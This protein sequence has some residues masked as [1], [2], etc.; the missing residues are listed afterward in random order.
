MPAAQTNVLVRLRHNRVV[1]TAPPPLEKR[2][3]GHPRWYGERFAFNDPAT[4]PQPDAEAT[5]HTTTKQGRRLVIHAQ[6]WYEMRLRGTRAYPMHRCP[7]TLVRIM[8]TTLEGTSVYR[9]PLW[10]ALFGPAR[11]ALSLQEIYAA[12]L[13]RFDQEHGQRFVKQ[14]LLATGY[15]TPE[16]AHE[17]HW[18]QMVLLAYFQLWLARGLARRLLR[19]WEKYLPR[20]RE[21]ESAE[22]SRPLSPA[23]VQRDFDR[24]IRQMGTPAQRFKPRGKPR[25]RA[26]GTRLPCRP[27]HSIVRKGRSQA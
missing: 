15:Q 18:W 5:W 10:L 25:G 14:H 17:V 3:S 21:Q 24:I 9:R 2:R 16:E 11:R 7:F 23:M 13:Q 22:T 19:P 6:A 20:W 12:Y 1:Y 8:V 26:K 27:R 4:W